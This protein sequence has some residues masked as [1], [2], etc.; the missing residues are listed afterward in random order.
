[1]NIPVWLRETENRP[2]PERTGWYRAD[3]LAKTLAA[4]QRAVTE[5]LYQANMANK[6][7]FLQQINP[8][9][10]VLGFLLAL[11]AIATA[12]TMA[13]L[14]LIHVLLILLSLMSK[15][16]FGAYCKRTW[17][18][19]MLFAGFAAIPA[20][21]NWITPGD[22]V[23]VILSGIKWQNSIITLPVDLTITRQGL[24]VAAVI[25]LRSA[26]TLGLAVLLV[27]TT[28][29]S[30]LTKALG[31]WGMPSVFV[32]VLDLTYRYIFLF[33]LLL[34]EYL[35]GRKSR[36]VG[37]ETAGSKLAWIGGTIAGFM[38]MATEYSKEIGMA[39]QARGYNGENP[40]QLPKRI[41]SADVC[42][43]AAQVLIW[44]SWWGGSYFA[45]IF[46]F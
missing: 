31:S 1:M 7:G 18:P 16:S 10:K 30:M 21:I 3:Y 20:V 15:I 4:I 40:Q 26:A 41:G 27:K 14:L 9:I 12:K 44:A 29:W 38:H 19:A 22:A 2:L 32:T 13:T 11:I 33:L 42:F 25:L 39:M 36:L 17:L 23:V 8:R 35:L 28:P 5:D 46:G 6:S 45:S 43:I 34:A 24:S 37:S